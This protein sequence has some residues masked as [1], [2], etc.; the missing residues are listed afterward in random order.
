MVSTAAV[1]LL[2][3]EASD[4]NSASSY[5][6]PNVMGRGQMR[7]GLAGAESIPI[8]FSFN[9]AGTYDTLLGA[10]RTDSEGNLA[11]GA[12]SYGVQGGFDVSGQKR[13]RRAVL[14]I[15][16]SGN[17][18]YF[19]SV[20]GFNGI[21][22]ALNLGYARRLSRRLEMSWMNTAS[23]TNRLLG[24]P[25]NQ[26]SLGADV[27]TAPVN[28][29]FDNRIYFLQSQMLY[30]FRLSSRWQIIGGGNGGMVRRK[31]AALADV[32]LYGASAG[33]LYRWDRNT[34]IGVNYTFSHFNFGRSFGESNLHG[35]SVNFGRKIG[36][37]WQ[38]SGSVSGQSI[39]TVGS[40]RVS[41]DPVIAALLGQDSGVEAFDSKRTITGF[42]VEVER[43]YRR[44]VFSARA[45]RGVVP[46]NG[47]LLTSV[48]DMQSVAMNYTANRNWSFNTGASRSS[49]EEITG[50]SLG[51]FD[52]WQAQASV[53]RT[54]NS[55]LTAFGTIEYRSF[56]LGR[57]TLDRRGTRYTVGITYT[58]TGLP[59]GR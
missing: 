35:V 55:E 5:D 23:V 57:S 1:V 37:D 3:Q 14:G 53:N 9:V 20:A 27:V 28:E 56:R 46:G 19:A 51:A 33:L 22:Q 50:S 34:S 58:P 49:M 21:N 40:R 44:S 11:P 38:V 26:Q 42:S 36:R 29:L 59:F 8:R 41:L 7:V 39:R 4:S 32:N 16:Y 6:G 10:F 43:R 31:A 24:N 45:D 48:I 15:S 54:L 12:G 47:L 25:L 30:T 2:A 17:Y 18:N 52:A 13:F